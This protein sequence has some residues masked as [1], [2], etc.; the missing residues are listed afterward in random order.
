LFLATGAAHAQRCPAGEQPLGVGGMASLLPHAAD[1]HVPGRA[2]ERYRLPPWPDRRCSIHCRLSAASA[3][4]PKTANC[5]SLMPR[6][7]RGWRRTGG[8]KFVVATSRRVRFATVRLT[9]VFL[10]QV[11]YF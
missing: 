9:F 1:E 11:W 5:R 6:P 4:R 3:Q 8:G 10:V 2:Y 7:P